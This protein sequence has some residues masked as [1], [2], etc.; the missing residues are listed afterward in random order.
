MARLP[1][2][3][4]LCLS[5]DNWRRGNVVYAREGIHGA[6][7]KAVR[8]RPGVWQIGQRVKLGQAIAKNANQIHWTITNKSGVRVATVEGSDGP[9]MGIVLLVWGLDAMSC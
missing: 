9:L 4:E 2:S 5:L 1:V 7:R 6:P 8:L 3:A